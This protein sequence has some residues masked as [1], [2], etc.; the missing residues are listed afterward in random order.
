VASSLEETLSTLEYANR[1]KN[2]KNKPEQTRKVA[3][4]RYISQ[5]S[6]E[7]ASLKTKYAL[8]VAQ[9]GGEWITTQEKEV[10]ACVW[11][12]QAPRRLWGSGRAA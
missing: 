2:I 6:T 3:H 4:G 12:L 11:G 1:A 7:M 10:R 9:A 5:V 8:Q